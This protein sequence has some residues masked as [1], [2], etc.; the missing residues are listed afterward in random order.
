VS[1]PKIV[2]Q[3]TVVTVWVTN[4]NGSRVSVKLT[5]DGTWYQGPRGEWYTSM[6]SNEQLRV[7][8]GF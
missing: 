2:V 5:R 6:P 3:P 1:R 8:Y 7:A 4:S